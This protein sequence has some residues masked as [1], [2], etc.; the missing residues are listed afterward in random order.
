MPLI[1]KDLHNARSFLRWE[2]ASES[3]SIV[4]SAY[5][6][7]PDQTWVMTFCPRWQRRSRDALRSVCRIRRERNWCF[8]PATAARMRLASLYA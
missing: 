6:T 2:E 4:A 3:E 5:T 7:P 8:S 1:I